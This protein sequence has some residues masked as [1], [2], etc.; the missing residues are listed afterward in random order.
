MVNK[1][2]T[3][4]EK[5]F[6]REN[7]DAMTLRDLAKALDRSE[8]GVK[9]WTLKL[10][11]RRNNRF[12]WT[13]DREAALVEFYP[14]HSA[15]YIAELL[16]TKDYV[17][18]KKAERMGLKKSPEY[19]AKL[20]K[21]LGENLQKG[22]FGTRFVKG[23]KPWCYG[24][25]IGSHPN[26]ARTQFKKGQNPHNALRVGDEV[27][28]DGYWKVKI[29]EPNKWE[30]KHRLLW[31]QAHGEIP[32]GQCIVFRDGNP[33]NCV[34]E[35]LECISRAELSRRNI[36]KNAPEVRETYRML[37]HLQRLINRKEKENAEK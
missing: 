27:C 33:K 22:G 35:N 7:F 29:A 9:T 4:Q 18:Y 11:L 6:I 17:I 28:P 32:E 31:K 15:K 36:E 26:S 24:K 13:E 19:L 34:I 25:K 30:F 8:G 10:G 20:N 21:Q 16:G 1:P 12:D 23:Q 14:N 37:G 2:F 3:A 5:D